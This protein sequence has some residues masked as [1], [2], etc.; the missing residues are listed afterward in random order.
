M[1]INQIIINI[2]YLF[3]GILSLALLTPFLEN[4]LDEIIKK[5][6][7]NQITES[8]FLDV[9]FVLT[10]FLYTSI[11]VNKWK[12]IF[13]NKSTTFFV[14][15]IF[16]FYIYQRVFNDHYIF[17][18]FKIYHSLAYLDVIIPIV[19]IYLGNFLKFF[20]VEKLS[21]EKQSLLYEDSP[22]SNEKDDELEN[23]FSKTV[24]KI[25]KIITKNNFDTSYTVGIN[26]EWGGGKSSILK[27]LKNRLKRDSNNVIVDFNP[28][29]G[30]DKKVLIKDFFNSLSEN[31][32]E[33]NIS[34]DIS[35]Y[36]K[37]LINIT[38]NSMLKSIKSIFYKEKSLETLFKNI[39]DKIKLLDKKVIIIVDDVDRLDKEEIFQLLKLIRNTANFSNT[40]FIVAYDR[41]YVI[42]S[43]SGINEYLA[44]NY[45]DKIINA[46]LTLPY[47]DK[48]ILKEIFKNKLIEKIGEQYRARIIY[49]LDFGMN[50]PDVF[51]NNEITINDFSIW[52]TNIRQIKK[53]VNSIYINFNG[54][55]NEI[56]FTDLIYLELL[57]LRYPYIY[58][59][60]YN[61][62]DIIFTEVKGQLY[63]KN[64]SHFKKSKEED[65]ESI[66]NTIFGEE[67]KIF[68]KTQNI[69]DIERQNIY[70]IFL[71]L[72]STYNNSITYFL[73][74]G[75]DP[76]EKLSISYSAKFERYFA[77]TIFKGNI[78]EIEFKIL[79]NSN[80]TERNETINK[81]INEGKEK[82]LVYR[83][84]SDI[85]YENK[86]EFENTINTILQLANTNSLVSPEYKIGYDLRTF[87]NKIQEYSG[88]E[89]FS[90]LYGA[91]EELRDF[92]YNTFI[93]APYPYFF[94][95]SVLKEITLNRH[96]DNIL[97]ALNNREVNY[98]LKCYFI[99]Y[100]SFTEKL[101]SNFFHLLINCKRIIYKGTNLQ[102]SRY[103]KLDKDIRGLIIEKFENTENCV[104]YLNSI[105][106]HE[107]D[108]I[109]AIRENSI[110]EIF[111]SLDNFEIEILNNIKDDLS[112][113][114]K[115]FKDFYYKVK[116]NRWKSINYD[117]KFFSFYQ[118]G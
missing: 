85:T 92:M 91:K 110:I 9:I 50:H 82:D 38:D 72:F 98:I 65:D 41:E 105:I 94:E 68:C 29:M 1:K 80:E 62:K 11:S 56:N 79:L 27:M 118:G 25:Q 10:L 103:F 21:N 39:N 4:T 108:N 70:M 104:F 13:P 48:D 86:I 95:S 109:A 42:N 46:E 28:W 99:T 112:N 44:A 102:Y 51:N 78:S 7:I 87:R 89:K 96:R 31:L 6:S 115:E 113:A 36:S 20:D 55:F 57:K 8:K 34:D 54:F 2:F 30:F 22:I 90:H 15:T 71:N 14:I 100:L 37:E 47:Y 69:N 26:S 53:L 5:F 23:L 83:F 93:N 17:V 117:F 88:N 40:F 43:I 64:N 107:Y 45:L 60:I 84:L 66:D 33:N 3:L 106:D 16:I 111:G 76:D 77:Q 63:I 18:G 114:Q 35:T 49:S 73:D 32:T 97:F 101:D 75:N 12:E 58:K 81:W 59:L 19:I 52:I 74:R 61:K 24:E 116:N 67:L